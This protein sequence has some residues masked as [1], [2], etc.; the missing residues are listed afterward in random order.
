MFNPLLGPLLFD[1]G[2]SGRSWIPAL[3]GAP[4][5]IVPFPLF[6]ISV[7]VLFEEASKLLKPK[8]TWFFI[9]K[10]PF[11]FIVPSLITFIFAT[12]L[13]SFIPGPVFVP[14]LKLVCVPCTS[15]PTFLDLFKVIVPVY[16][17]GLI[18]GSS[19]LIPSS[20]IKALVSSTFT[21]TLVLI[22]SRFLTLPQVDI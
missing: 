9:P 21:F 18:S 13:I 1:H 7:L 8:A 19:S 5:V 10:P 12:F 17:N 4:K 15:I 20:T 3:S 14:S 6:I 22:P 11:P 16:L 2:S